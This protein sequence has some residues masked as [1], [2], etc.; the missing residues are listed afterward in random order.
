MK[1]EIAVGMIMV[2]I[3][4]IALFSGCIQ[5][6]TLSTPV[7]EIDAINLVKESEMYRSMVTQYGL[8]DVSIASQNLYSYNEYKEISP[9]FPY[10]RHPELSGGSIWVIEVHITNRHGLTAIIDRDTG[11]GKIIDRKNGMTML[12]GN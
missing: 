12:L 7:S 11:K 3:F 1:K 9:I 8:D 4:C 5:E 2:G 10:D 6:R